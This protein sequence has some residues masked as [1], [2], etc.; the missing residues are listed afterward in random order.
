VSVERLQF[1][2][3]EGS[4]QKHRYELL[5]KEGQ[6]IGLL[7]ENL[8]QPGPMELFGYSET[9][10]DMLVPIPL[11]IGILLIPTGTHEKYHW[12]MRLNGGPLQQVPSGNDKMRRLMASLCEKAPMLAAELRSKTSSYNAANL[13]QLVNCYNETV[14]SH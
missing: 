9:K 11:P 1:L 10:N 13:Q 12:Y 5:K 4:F 6:S 8:A 3:V 2:E 7:A 14:A